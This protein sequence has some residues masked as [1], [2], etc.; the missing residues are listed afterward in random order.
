MVLFTSMRTPWKSWMFPIWSDKHFIIGK[1]LH[2]R[3]KVNFKNYDVTSWSTE[4]CNKQIPK[5]VKHIWGYWHTKE[6]V[7]EVILILEESL[8]PNYNNFHNLRL[9]CCYKFSLHQK[10]NEAQ[11][12]VLNMAYTS[13]LTRCRSTWDFRS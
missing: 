13:C 10:W 7:D 6:I 4:N 1:Q 5:Y 8:F 3:A 11:L 12:L 9:S 2:E